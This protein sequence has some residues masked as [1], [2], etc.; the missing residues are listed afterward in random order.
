MAFLC[1]CAG[2]VCALLTLLRPT[3]GDMGLYLTGMLLGAGM[4]GKVVQKSLSEAPP[5]PPPDIAS[6]PLPRLAVCTTGLVC[7][8]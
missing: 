2:I 6:K 7:H 1:V 3:S 4:T 5:I 8:N